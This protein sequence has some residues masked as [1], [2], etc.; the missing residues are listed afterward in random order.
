MQAVGNDGILKNCL[1]FETCLEDRFV[2]S[3]SKNDNFWD[4]DLGLEVLPN[5]G[6]GGSSPA[7]ITG[8]FENDD[9]QSTHVKVLCR[10]KKLDKLPIHRSSGFKV[11]IQDYFGKAPYF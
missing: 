5:S 11:A 10:L 4:P 7:Y 6:I 8:M 1:G 2:D 3:Q 9:E